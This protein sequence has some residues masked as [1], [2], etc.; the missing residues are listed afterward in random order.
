MSMNHKNSPYRYNPDRLPDSHFEK[1]SFDHLVVGNEGRALDYR[2]TPVG[3][4]E[5]REGSG[6]VILEIL[7]FEDKGNTWEIP[8]EDVGSFQFALESKH[9]DPN[10][11][12]R[13]EA[14]SERLNR[15][16]EI[17]CME[18]SRS[19][20]DAEVAEAEREA[21]EWLRLHSKALRE[22]VRPDFS[23]N[24]GLVPLYED[25]EAYMKHHDLGENESTF[26]AHYVCK[27]HYSES[28][29]AQRIA[30]AEM[31]LVPYQGKI[32]REEREIQG[33][34][35]KER[36]REHVIRRLAFVR[37]FY[38]EAGVASVVL[39]RGIHSAGL[40]TRPRNRTFV[41]A[42]TNPAIAES[43]ACLREPSNDNN[44]GRKVGVLMSQ[45]IPMDRVFM[46]Y[47]ETRR[48][49]DPYVES[50]AVLLYDPDEAF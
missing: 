9:P 4:R 45:D 22:G 11:R 39:Y 14:I 37:A 33:R 24:Q 32:L 42:T 25:I 26:A 44:P 29:K 28:V 6:L 38:A 10:A 17:A 50:E 23:R 43:L 8:L 12:S 36:R 3:V 19:R 7:D 34:F 1:G 16:M 18:N 47:M 2:R 49:N 40:P 35:S 31:G 20:T 46:T 13:Y 15:R 5:I 41:S 30:I 48:M 21:R 27:F